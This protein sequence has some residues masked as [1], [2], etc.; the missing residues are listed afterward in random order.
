MKLSL[1]NQSIVHFGI[2]NTE[3][4]S[5]DRRLQELVDCIAM[6]NFESKDKLP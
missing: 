3:R 2:N 4:W 5:I 6:N 1:S